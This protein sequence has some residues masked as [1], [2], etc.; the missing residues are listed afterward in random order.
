MVSTTASSAER[1]LPR[2]C[3]RSGWVQTSGCSN[4]ALTSSRRSFLAS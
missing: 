2:A 1:S 3:A 4:S